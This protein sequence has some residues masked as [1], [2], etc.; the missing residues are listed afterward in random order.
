[1]L[2]LALRVRDPSLVMPSGGLGQSVPQK[3]NASFL[4][5]LLTIEGESMTCISSVFTIVFTPKKYFCRSFY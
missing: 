4:K 2:A 1:M 3:V 5:H